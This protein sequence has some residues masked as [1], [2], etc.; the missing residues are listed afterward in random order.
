MR[1]GKIAYAFAAILSLVSVSSCSSSSGSQTPSPSATGT[2]IGTATLPPTSTVTAVSTDTDTTGVPSWCNQYA[3]T[4][5]QI[6]EGAGGGIWLWT[7]GEEVW[8]IYITFAWQST[9]QVRGYGFKATDLNAA[10][11]YLPVPSEVNY[12]GV[13][14]TNC[15]YLAPSPPNT[16]APTISASVLSIGGNASASNGSCTFTLAPDQTTFPHKQ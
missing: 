7:C 12:I 10:P 8:N 14:A 13:M 15:L 9:S 11:A 4:A 16:T 1:S 2:G 6:G 5:P 3:Y